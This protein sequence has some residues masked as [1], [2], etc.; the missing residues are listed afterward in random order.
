MQQ[1]IGSV[2]KMFSSELA[3]LN[4][5]LLNLHQ[6]LLGGHSSIQQ[7]PPVPVVHIENQPVT[8]AAQGEDQVPAES[9]ETEAA[10]DSSKGSKESTGHSQTKR[11]TDIKPAIPVKPTITV[12]PGKTS[13][14][15]RRV[16]AA[17]EKVQLEPDTSRRRTTSEVPVVT[18]KPATGEGTQAT[19]A[20]KPDRS[21]H[22]PADT[23]TDSTAEAGTGAP[24]TGKGEV[25]SKV[26]VELEPKLL[27]P[28]EGTQT[29]APAL[30]PA[31]V[32]PPVAPVAVASGNAGASNASPI[33][34][35]RVSNSFV[36]FTSS[37][38]EMQ[39]KLNSLPNLGFIPALFASSNSRR[40][41]NSLRD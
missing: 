6:Q 30:E 14:S 33:D 34:A 11:S 20:A 39:R 4:Q 19:A 40:L 23:K 37:L 26:S 22:S 2:V 16:K 9:L 1:Q 31:F 15:S 13:T 10:V 25:K 3:R 35:S 12:A 41:F 29:S 38:N 24:Q 27:I 32:E 18:D 5:M 8:A 36:R 7:I 28:Y 17:Q 21:T